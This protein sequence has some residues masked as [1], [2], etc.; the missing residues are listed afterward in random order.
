MKH[1]SSDATLVKWKE[2]IIEKGSSKPPTSTDKQ[3][4]RSVV[5]VPGRRVIGYMCARPGGGAGEYAS[6]GCI[7]RRGQ[8]HH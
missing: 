3:T 7:Q 8:G 6:S 1:W 2:L 4:I 5:P